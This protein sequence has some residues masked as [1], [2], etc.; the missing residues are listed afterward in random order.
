MR[1]LDD[2]FSIE[3]LDRFLD[4]LVPA[5]GPAMDADPFN[6]FDGDFTHEVAKLRKFFRERHAYLRTQL[7][8]STPF[9]VVINE[10][11]ASNQ[12]INTDEGGRHADWVELYNRGDE[13]AS[14]LG[15]YLSDDPADRRRWKLP[16]VALLSAAKCLSGATSTLTR[17]R[18]TRASSST[19]TAS[20][21]GSRDR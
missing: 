8:A 11:L 5:I 19:P 13:P 14:L 18:S 4:E 10:V 2:A 16:D 9:A 1:L 6:D 21:W 12:S 15:L 17:A 3:A 20:R 7:P